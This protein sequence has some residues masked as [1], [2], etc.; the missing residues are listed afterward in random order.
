LKSPAWLEQ[1]IQYAERVG[2]ALDEIEDMQKRIKNLAVTIDTRRV[3]SRGKTRDYY[4]S[5]GL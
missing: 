1:S 2:I 4:F 3:V 5:H